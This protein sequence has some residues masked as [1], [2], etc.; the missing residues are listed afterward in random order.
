[1]NFLTVPLIKPVKAHFLYLADQYYQ[2]LH[3]EGLVPLAFPGYPPMTLEQFLRLIQ[4]SEVQVFFV[5]EEKDVIPVA[6]VVLKDFNGLSATI[7]YCIRKAYHGKAAP[8]IGK[9]LL[10]DLEKIKRK[11][12]FPF[13]STLIG[14]TPESNRAARIYLRRMGFKVYGVIENFFQVAENAFENAVVSKRLLGV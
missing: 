2:H 7:H 10:A 1:M 4:R 8:I 13:V 11:D 5:F 12:G 14:T 3:C 6:H 9:Q